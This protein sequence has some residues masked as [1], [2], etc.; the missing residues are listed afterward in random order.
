MI[1]WEFQNKRLFPA[2]LL[3]PFVYARLLDTPFVRSAS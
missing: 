2:F 3:Q 1:A